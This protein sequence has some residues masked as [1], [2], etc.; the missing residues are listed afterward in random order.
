MS[1]CGCS[2]IPPRSIVGNAEVREMCGGITRHT[3]I[4]WREREDF[5]KPVRRL[6]LSDVELW[7]ARQVR[8]WYRARLDRLAGDDL[9]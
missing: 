9:P 8:A 6:P 1:S 4:R 7:D 5:P 3:L 2:G